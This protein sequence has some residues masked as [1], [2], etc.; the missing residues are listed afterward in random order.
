MGSSVL[1]PIDCPPKTSQIYY[2]YTTEKE[3]GEDIPKEAQNKLGSDIPS[4]QLYVEA[5]DPVDTQQYAKL[6]LSNFNLVRNPS[7][8][9]NADGIPLDWE[10]AGE[11]VKEAGLVYGLAE[12]SSFGFR[13]AYFN[14]PKDAP[15]DWCGWRQTVDVKPNTHYIYGAWV[16]YEDTDVAVDVEGQ[17]EA[18]G[19]HLV[20][21]G[22]GDVR[23][24]AAFAD[25]VIVAIDDVRAGTRDEEIRLDEAR[26]ERGQPADLAA[27]AEAE[28]VAGLLVFADLFDRLHRELV[29]VLRFIEIQRSVKIGCKYFF[30]TTKSSFTEGFRFQMVM[31][32][33]SLFV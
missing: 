19:A 5:P 7:F 24:D 4:D 23:V 18:F 3:P 20:R 25:L 9:K 17:P 10:C 16:A 12:P 13:H 21:D 6:V 15:K 28:E 1:F 8:E 2:V 32:T 26:D 33:L 14:V 27:G 30:H 29:G 22:P 31:S 11:K